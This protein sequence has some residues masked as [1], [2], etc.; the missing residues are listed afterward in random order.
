MIINFRFRFKKDWLYNEYMT[1]KTS[2]SIKERISKIDQQIEEYKKCI[3]ALEEVK[4]ENC[5]INRTS[6]AKDK[7]EF[8]L[9][10]FYARRDV[11]ALRSK[12]KENKT[13]YYPKCHYF[14]S[15]ACKK[16]QIKE[17]GIKGGKNICEDCSFKIYDE[18]TADVVIKNNLKNNSIDGINAVGIYPIFNGDCV[19]FV[20]FD[21]D[22]KDWEKSSRIVVDVAKE[23]GFE[24]RESAVWA[25]SLIAVL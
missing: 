18:L 17:K 13:T 9:D 12:N 19:R 14:W 16:R 1:P 25:I 2:S 4:N 8:L 21:F 3:E 15:E 24:L 7:A 6:S 23:Y 11:Y 20:A 10:L 5:S 22:E